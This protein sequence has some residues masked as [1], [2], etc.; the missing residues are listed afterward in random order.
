V[1]EEEIHMLR[2]S[3]VLVKNKWCTN[4]EC[5]SFVVSRGLAYCTTV[6]IFSLKK[7]TAYFC[8]VCRGVCKALLRR[9][10]DDM[11]VFSLSITKISGG[12]TNMCKTPSTSLIWTS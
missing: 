6:R 4:L 12:I 8:D 10:A 9:W 11:D 5:V 2:M 3:N 1:A 7:L